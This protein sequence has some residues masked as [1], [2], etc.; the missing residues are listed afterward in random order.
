ML[1]FITW[2]FSPSI[3]WLNC[4]LVSVTW[5]AKQQGVGGTIIIP[6]VIPLCIKHSYANIANEIKSV[7]FNARWYTKYIYHNTSNQKALQGLFGFSFGYRQLYF[8]PSIEISL[9]SPRLVE[10]LLNYVSLFYFINFLLKSKYDWLV[11]I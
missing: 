11:K 8:A 4:Q 7:A 10:I 5:Q 3:D 6:C 2:S 9:I 1:F